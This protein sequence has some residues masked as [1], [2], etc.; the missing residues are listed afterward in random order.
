MCVCVC[1][2]CLLLRPSLPSFLDAPFHSW[3]DGKQSSM[4][5]IHTRCCWRGGARKDEMAWAKKLL[6]TAEAVAK[7]CKIIAQQSRSWIF[8]LQFFEVKLRW[9]LTPRSAAAAA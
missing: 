1:V 6:R 5:D 4:E 9:F 2:Y 7:P 8:T 3:R